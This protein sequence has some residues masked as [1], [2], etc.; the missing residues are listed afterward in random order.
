MKLTTTAKVLWAPMDIQRPKVFANK[1]SSNASNTYKFFF[2]FSTNLGRI[3]FVKVLFVRNTTHGHTCNVKHCSQTILT[4]Q[5]GKQDLMM[6]R[7]KS[8]KNVC[9]YLWSFKNGSMEL[10]K[11]RLGINPIFKIF[12]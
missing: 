1:H 3:C 10:K 8:C 2:V 4:I 7:A 9:C 11:V 12:Y 5:C 6:K